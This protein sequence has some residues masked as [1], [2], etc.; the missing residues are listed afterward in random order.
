MATTTTTT[1]PVTEVSDLAQ[2]IR[3]Q[4]MST[5]QQAQKLSVDAA[6]TW[7]KA[8]SAIPAPRLP[9]IPGVRSVPGIE[10]VTTYTFDLAADLLTAQRDFALQLAKVL[11]TESSAQKSAGHSTDKPAEKSV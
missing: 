6:E 11:A 8:A 7:L 10:A 9:S 3:E 5:V 1:T 2:K 4:L